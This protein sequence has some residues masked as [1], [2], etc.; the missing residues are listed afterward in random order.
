MIVL[1]FA[2]R[3]VAL[4]VAGVAIFIVIGVVVHWLK[5]VRLRRRVRKEWAGRRVLLVYSNSP[6]WQHYFESRWFPVLEPHIVKLNWS[7]RSSWRQDRNAVGPAVFRHYLGSREEF[8]PAA[9]VFMDRGQVEIV[10]FWKAFRDY[11][12]GKT[13]SLDEQQRRLED[14]LKMIGIVVEIPRPT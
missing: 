12:H 10:R 1:A 3:L 14:L 13:A 8:N 6:N 5:G 2:L 9:V 11:K 4:I 7:D